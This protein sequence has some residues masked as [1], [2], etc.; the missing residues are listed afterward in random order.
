MT[1]KVLL[2]EG[3]NLTG[4]NILKNAGLE[5]ETF[6]KA[7]PEDQLKEKIKDVHAIGIRSKTLLTADVLKEAKKPFGYWM[8]LYWNQPSELGVCGFKRGWSKLNDR[9][10]EEEGREAG[11]ELVIAEIIGLSR[12]VTDRNSEMHSG[13]W[14]KNALLNLHEIKG[15]TLGIV[16]YGHIGSQLL[17]SQTPLESALKSGHLAGAAVDVFPV[18]PFT[19][20]K[21][22]STELQN[23]PNTILSPHIGGST[24]EA[25]SAIGVEVASAVLKYL[26]TGS[27]FGTVNFPEVDLRQISA[28]KKVLRVLNCHHNVPG[29]L[30]ILSE[31]NIEKQICDS[32]G[33]IGYLVAD[34]QADR[35]VDLKTISDAISAMP[36]NITTRFL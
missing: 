32:K 23:S 11:T 1:Y 16:G 3:V 4:V 35:E 13:V 5:V 26:Q 28:K 29:V 10:K 22:F 20:G 12:Q 8:L 21:N 25:Q 31:F 18:E 24:E 7:L 14:N 27:T 2:L 36:E 34:L 30:K 19:N 17:C 15:K 33:S 6:A 9:W